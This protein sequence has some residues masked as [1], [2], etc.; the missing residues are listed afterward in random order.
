MATIRLMPFTLDDLI[1]SILLHPPLPCHYFGLN[2][3]R[4]A[5][6]S[7]LVVD[8]TIGEGHKIM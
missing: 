7:F 2:I 6:K 5:M 3:P 4:F 1:S 8:V